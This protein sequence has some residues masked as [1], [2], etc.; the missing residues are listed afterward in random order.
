M[1][2]GEIR[3]TVMDLIGP[4]NGMRPLSAPI[5]DELVYK[6]CHS[7]FHEIRNWRSRADTTANIVAGTASYDL[8][9]DYLVMESVVVADASGEFAQINPIRF[10]EQHLDWGDSGVVGYYVDQGSTVA[11][12]AIVLVPT[13]ATSATNGL[14]IRY[15]RRPAK[16][17]TFAS[18]DTEFTDCD[19]NLH[20]AICYEA[21]F[22]Y[23]S[24]QGSKGIKDFAGYHEYF[25]NEVGLEKKRNQETWQTDFIPTIN[26]RFGGLGE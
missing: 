2:C 1:T 4:H 11:L 17:S 10:D 19:A 7:V 13:P 12:A 24:R 26:I 14:K 6:A 15:R 18:V 20:L 25:Q 16:L 22:L 8:P 21:A 3:A 5:V 9:S 23:L